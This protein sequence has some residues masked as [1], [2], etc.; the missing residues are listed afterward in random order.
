MES[1]INPGR[2]DLE[3][4]R[5]GILRAGGDETRTN[6]GDH[7]HVTLYLKS[8]NWRLSYDDYGNGDY[9]NVHTTNEKLFHMSYKGLL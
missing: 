9:R 1:Y 7:I 4:A 5:E 8:R 3:K 2:I 6:K